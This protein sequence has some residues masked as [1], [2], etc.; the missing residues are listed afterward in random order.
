[1]PH[2]VAQD[3]SQKDDSYASLINVFK[4][5]KEKEVVVIAGEFH[6][7]V[8]SNTENYEDQHGGN[9]YEVRNKERER[10]L[11]I[12]AAM[13]ITVGNTLFK[14]RASHL[15]AYEYG[16]SQA[17]VKYCLVRRTKISF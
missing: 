12:C 3:D 1:M 7:H 17:Q 4:K 9:G 6:G 10:V 13:N 2:N 15:V 14:K 16:S 5:L 11:E 8:G